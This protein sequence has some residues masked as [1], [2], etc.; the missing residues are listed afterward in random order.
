VSQQAANAY[1]DNE[2]LRGAYWRA[3]DYLEQGEDFAQAAAVAKYWVAKSGHKAAHTFLHLH[4]GMGQDLEY[5][6]HRFFLWAKFCE[7]YLG[8]AD[9]LILGIGDHVIET[10]QVEITKA[11]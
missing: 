11:S 9:D 1:M 5:P 2:A 6:I 8:S 4:G 3:L 10:A 7:R